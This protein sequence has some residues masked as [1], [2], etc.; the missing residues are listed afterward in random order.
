MTTLDLDRMLSNVRDGQWS[1]DDLDWDRPLQGADALSARE[2]KEAG[3]ALLFTAGLERQAAK[4]FRLCGKYVD[5]PR[6]KQIY[7]LFYEDEMRHAEAEIRLARRFGA[8]WSDLPLAARW[9]FRT[10]RKNFETGPDR[11]VH[12][13]SSATIVLFELA[14]DSILIPALKSLADD[15]LTAEVFRRI[16]IDESRHLAMDYWLLDRKGT[17]FGGRDMI[18][19]LEAEGVRGTRLDRLRGRY[20]LYRTG[21]AFLI[22]FATTHLAMPT[23][24]EATSDPALLGR[25]LRRVR[26]IPKKAPHAMDVPTY[27][28]GLNG[29]E[30]ILRLLHRLG[31]Q[32]FRREDYLQ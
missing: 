6:A 13:L 1:V 22:G 17:Y 8:Q 16:D 11:G 31:G 20:R 18:E 23:M 26:A 14:L 15:P 29:Q 27:R 25:Y 3:M 32:Q 12:E 10:L 5:D 7:E 30:M 19:V 21:V 28:T 4:I 24:R 2:R 9:M